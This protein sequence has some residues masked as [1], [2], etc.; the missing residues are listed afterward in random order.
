METY[1]AFT[2]MDDSCPEKQSVYLG[3]LIMAIVRIRISD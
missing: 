1:A 2:E 3:G